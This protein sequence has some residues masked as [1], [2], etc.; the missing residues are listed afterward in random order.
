MEEHLVFADPTSASDGPCPAGACAVDQFALSLHG[1]AVIV[2]CAVPGLTPAVARLFDPFHAALLGRGLPITGAIRPYDD[3]V[4]GHLSANARRV[5][6][7]R[8]ARGELLELYEDGERFWLVDERWGLTEIDLSEQS[9]RSWVLPAPR[10]DPTRCAEAAVMWPLAQLLRAAGVHLVPAASV[11]REGWSALLLCPF[12]PE[13]E[14]TTLLDAGWRVIGQRWTAVR[15]EE[16]RLALLHL[17]GWVERAVA[18]RLR[19]AVAGD[20][21]GSDGC[22]DLTAGRYGA[23]QRHAFCD[24]VLITEPARLSQ[25][26]VRDLPTSEATVAALRRAWPIVELGGADRTGA[27]I[28][29]LTRACRVAEVQLSRNPRDLLAILSDLRAAAPAPRQM[30]AA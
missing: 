14:L 24:A 2:D 19:I 25:A 9:W 1:P 20:E 10:L 6:S 23:V 16:G 5:P 4:T 21:T 15:E 7:C 29:S 8:S 13:P 11:V 30:L 17:P 18:P 22:A 27:V 3:D 28:G 12:S 26:H